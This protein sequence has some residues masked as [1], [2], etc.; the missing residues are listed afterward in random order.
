MAITFQEFDLQ[1]FRT[2][3]AKMSEAELLSLVAPSTG[4][5]IREP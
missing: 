4:C 5:A 2:K 3:I 1:Q